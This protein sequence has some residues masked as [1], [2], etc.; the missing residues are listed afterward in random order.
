MAELDRATVP[1]VSEERNDGKKPAA[2]RKPHRKSR[3]GC[4]Q[5]R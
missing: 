2:K 5:C 3:T 4:K 1:T